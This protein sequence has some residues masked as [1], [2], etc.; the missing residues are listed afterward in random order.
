MVHHP[1][2]KAKLALQATRLLWDPR[3]HETQGRSGKGTWRDTARSI[4]EPVWA[5][6]MMLLAL[7]G[8]FLAVDRVFVVLTASLLVY[9]TIAAMIFAGTTRY[10]VSFDFLLVMLA[11][12]A[13]D[14]LLSKSRYTSSTPSAAASAEN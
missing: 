7:A 9:N 11:G 5:I 4:V 2:E 3:S 10:R 8:I 1:G 6:P 13:V 12:A 14:R